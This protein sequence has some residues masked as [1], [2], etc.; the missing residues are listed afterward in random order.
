MHVPGHAW[1]IQQLRWQNFAIFWPPLRGQFLYT[2]P[3][4]NRHFWQPPPHLPHFVHVVIEWPLTQDAY[5]L[6]SYVF[7]FDEYFAVGRKIRIFLQ[8]GFQ[9]KSEWS[10]NMNNKSER[11]E[12]LLT[13]LPLPSSHV[14]F[15]LYYFE[16]S[17]PFLS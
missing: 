6:F 7:N 1:V 2:E 5:L 10:L 16:T 4:Q 11:I 12:E 17:N 3:W 13:Y 8:K 9:F 15:H 14:P